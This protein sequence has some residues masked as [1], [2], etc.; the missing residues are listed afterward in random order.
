ME[1]PGRFN[2]FATLSGL[3]NRESDGGVWFRIDGARGITVKPPMGE[4]AEDAF[5]EHMVQSRN[6][7][8]RRQSVEDSDGR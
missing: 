6:A 4:K 8:I 2:K 7:F 1:T 5:F 3:L